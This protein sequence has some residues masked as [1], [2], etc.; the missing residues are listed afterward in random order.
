MN[1][2]EYLKKIKEESNEVSTQIKNELKTLEQTEKDFNGI[3]LERRFE[4]VFTYNK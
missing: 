2:E 4:D 1:L 3:V